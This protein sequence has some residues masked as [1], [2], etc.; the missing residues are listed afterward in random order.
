[1]AYVACDSWLVRQR[2][3]LYQRRLRHMRPLTDGKTLRKRGLT[4]GPQFGRI[5]ERLRAAWLDD[6]IHDAAGE[7]ALLERLLAESQGEAGSSP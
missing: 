2:I 1:M 4:P 7:E 3:E 6:E 5:I